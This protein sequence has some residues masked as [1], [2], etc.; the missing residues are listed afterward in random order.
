[1]AENGKGAAMSWSVKFPESGEY[2]ELVLIDSLDSREIRQCTDRVIDLVLLSGCHL[3]LINCL[4]LKH[5]PP[6]SAVRKL[7]G[8]YESRGINTK[9]KIALI[10]S[11]LPE[12]LEI[13]RYYKLAAKQQNYVV[14]LFETREDGLRWLQ[15]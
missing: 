1:M 12:G 10:N 13:A 5:F 7:P 8:Y 3:V 4:E 15:T 2:I 6:P 11:G 9:V 14:Q